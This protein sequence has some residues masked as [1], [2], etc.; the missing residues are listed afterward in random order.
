MATNKENIIVDSMDEKRSV[1]NKQF[2]SFSK[3]FFIDFFLINFSFF[4]VH[5]F[6]RGVVGLTGP[7]LRLLFLFYLCWFIS[8]IVGKK[9]KIDSYTTFGTSTL[10]LLRSSLYLTYLIA[11]FVVVLGLASFSRIHIFSTCLVLF[12]LEYIVWFVYNKMFNSETID[13]NSFKNILDSIWLENNI[14]W[15]LVFMDLFLVIF[16]F[17]MVNYLKRGQLA[18]LP[19]YS[20]LFIIFFGVW[21]VISAMTRKFSIEKFRNVHFF[22]WKWIKAGAL[23]L[24]TMAALVFG[25]RLFY[26][27]RFQSL[28]SILLLTV[29]EFIMINFYYRIS[30]TKEAIPDIESV[31]TVRNVLKQDNIPLEVDIDIIRQK[32]ME[33]AGKRFKRRIA[34]ENSGLFEFIDQHINLDDMMRMETAIER[35]CDM[36]D[37]N[38]DR[39]PVRVFMNLWKIND[40]RRVNAYFLEMHQMLLPGGYFIGHAH[41]IDTHYK[42]MFKKFPRYMAWVIYLVDFGFRRVMPKLPGLQKVYFFLTKGKNRLISRAELLG[43]LS[44]CG[45]EI[46]AEKVIG[47]KHYVIARKVKTTSLDTSPTYG[48]LVQL[49]RS[50]F[51]GETI[52]TYKFRTMHPYSEY[53]Q[54]YI[55]DLQGLQKGGKIE[56]DFRMTTWGKYMRKFWLDE[57]PMLYNW[58]KGDV[59]IVGVRPLSFHY[60]DLYDKDLQDLRKKVKPGLVPPFYAD[61]PET[62][63]EICDSER[64][65]INAFLK[66]PF[67]TQCIYFY[68]AFVNIAIKGA[69]SK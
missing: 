66:R 35:S 19:D 21:F 37:L 23:M 6:K 68:K 62:V 22:T 51:G 24:A 42:W 12:F 3:I 25:A 33:P 1:D 11:F 39:M 57:L 9:F 5:F 44:F 65:Y 64:R 17:F 41:T 60:L 30:K 59:G 8:A 63:E 29:L 61:L 52:H 43:R 14:S 46:V 58:I 20:K 2:I 27:S 16:S 13:K 31:K 69:R 50:G 32:L 48:P 38:S 53:L 56:N 47:N 7:Y 10:T 18:L 40:I 4:S 15:V 55:Y 36:L 26:F 28:G 34:S 45:F 54:Q 67:R 49:K